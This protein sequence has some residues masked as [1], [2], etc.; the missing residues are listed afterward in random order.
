MQQAFSKE[1]FAKMTYKVY[2]NKKS[3]KDFPDFMVWQSEF[4]KDDMGGLDPD[5]VFR[6]LCFMYDPQ[7]PFSVYPDMNKRRSLVMREI[8]IE[9]PYAPDIDAMLR[10]EN[11]GVNHRTILFLMIIGGEKYA[12]WQHLLEKQI[13]VMETEVN[14]EDKDAITAEKTKIEILKTINKEITEAKKDFLM[15]EKS[16]ELEKE[17]THFT[18]QETLGLRPE[19]YVRNYASS[20]DPFPKS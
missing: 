5:F 7:S 18:L 1:D 2:G 16:R 13:K 11:K 3:F 15:G 12:L 6:F 9:P 19:E 17:L 8:E 4:A 14:L 20:G 10:F